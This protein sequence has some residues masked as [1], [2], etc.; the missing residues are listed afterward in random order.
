M[1][2]IKLFSSEWSSKDFIKCT[3]LHIYL[4]NLYN[5][6]SIKWIGNL[7][8]ITLWAVNPR[9]SVNLMTFIH[10]KIRHRNKINKVECT[11]RNNI[12]FDPISSI[13]IRFWDRMKSLFVLNWLHNRSEYTAK[14]V[15]FSF[16]ACVD[17]T[18]W[19]HLS[20][21]SDW[22]FKIIALFFVENED[23]SHEKRIWYMSANS[24]INCSSYCIFLW[25]VPRIQTQ[26]KLWNVI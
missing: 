8:S 11:K 9:S 26:S 20:N 13:C 24:A 22:Q 14:W 21:K 19:L 3:T 15:K 7:I 17:P 6:N 18:D 4:C 2:K 12:K 10:T 25:S 5:N 1:Y 16:R 23:V